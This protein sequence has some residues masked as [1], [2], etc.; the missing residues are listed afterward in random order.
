MQDIQPTNLLCI[1]VVFLGHATQQQKLLSSPW[2]GVF[3]SWFSL[4][5]S[6]PEECFFTAT[7]MWNTLETSKQR[8]QPSWTS[9]RRLERIKSCVNRNKDHDER[10]TTGL[11]AVEERIPTLSPTQPAWSL[12][13][14]LRA[15]ETGARRASLYIY[16]YIYNDDYYY[17]YYYYYYY[18][19]IML[20][21]L[22]LL[23]L[24]IMIIIVIKLL[25]SGPRGGLPGG[26]ARGAL[27]PGSQTC[28]MYI[29]IYKYIN[30]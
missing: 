27:V 6:S 30:Q 1:S 8:G 3:S 11:R 22:L 28:W 14:S 21:L 20:L 23:L 25:E 17:Y 12:S 18:L 5:S 29:L 16:I 7:G 10:L 13:F 26:S 24:I 19:I 9:L 15:L 2:F 4:G